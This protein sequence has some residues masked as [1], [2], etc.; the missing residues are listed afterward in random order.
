[1]KGAV[2][3]IILWIL[4]LPVVLFVWLVRTI[5]RIPFWKIA[6]SAAI[7]CRTCRTPIS[8][9]G[10]WECRCG[11][12]SYRGHALRPCPVCNSLPRVA[13]CLAC[14]CTMLLPEDR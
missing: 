2:A 12:W 6:Y 7:P 5:Q 1:M 14:G 3:D 9:L 8:L 13:R 10:N 4:S 11:H